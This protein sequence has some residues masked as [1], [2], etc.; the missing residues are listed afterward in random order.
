MIRI[1]HWGHPVAFIKTAE[2]A[3]NFVKA[4]SLSGLARA[5][6]LPKPVTMIDE[7]IHREKTHILASKC[8]PYC[9]S[10]ERGSPRYL[11]VSQFHVFLSW[12][13]AEQ[14]FAE[15][16]QVKRNQ[17]GPRK[18]TICLRDDCPLWVQKT[19]S[20]W[21][22]S[23]VISGSWA[24]NGQQKCRASMEVKFVSSS[25]PLLSTFLLSGL[26]VSIFEIPFLASSLLRLT[27]VK[28]NLL[29][30]NSCTELSAQQGLWHKL[31]WRLSHRVTVPS[32][33]GI[34]V[35]LEKAMDK[36]GIWHGW[37]CRLKPVNAHIKSQAGSRAGEA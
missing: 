25:S 31:Q 26:S 15:R 12:L 14:E 37:L 29:G 10:M 3:V 21:L 17:S 33:V 16:A 2:S 20:Q 23:W 36:E 11:K 7:K 30:T 9:A 1:G 19:Q 4:K 8:L 24:I 35:A 5:C 32:F 34:P 27:E 28:N 22:K 18:H 13:G 6:F